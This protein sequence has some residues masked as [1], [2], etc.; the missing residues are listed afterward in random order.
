MRTSESMQLNRMLDQ[1]QDRAVYA[2][3]EAEKNSTKVETYQLLAEKSEAECKHKDTQIENL[4]QT[5]E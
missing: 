4:H 2:I 5:I 1:Q 3:R